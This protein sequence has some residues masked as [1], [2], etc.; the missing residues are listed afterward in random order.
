[1]R[2]RREPWPMTW[3]RRAVT[4]PVVFLVGLVVLATLPLWV[5]LA[6][7]AAPFEPR[8]W[9]ALRSVG[10]FT[11]YLVGEMLFLTLAFGQWIA[12]GPWTRAGAERLGRWTDWLGDAWGATLHACGRIWFGLTVDVRGLEALDEGGPLLVLLRHASIGDT[13]LAPVYLARHAGLRLRYVAKSELRNDPIFDVIGSRTR[14]AFV[15]RGSAHAAR[16]I[17]AVCALLDELGPRDAI[18]IYPE[19]TRFSTEKR[20]RVLARLADQLEPALLARARGLR[21]VLPPRLGGPIALLERN[22][23]AD[24]VF[25]THVGY[26]GAATFGDLLGGRAIGQRVEVEFR[27]VKYAQIPTGR[28]ALV[29]WLYDEWA[30]VDAWIDERGARE[31]APAARAGEVVPPRRPRRRDAARELRPRP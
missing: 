25:C 30:R 3:R 1:M 15:E 26:E 9:A 23:G 29:R 13:P 24:V 17:E 12:A 14:S 22:P 6:I 8:R 5:L 10:F 11:T 31:A 19:G 28:E 4:I 20:A 2:V 27:R 21:H 18:V 16:E 7:A